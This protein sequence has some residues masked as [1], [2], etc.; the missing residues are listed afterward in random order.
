MS[1]IH[2]VQLSYNELRNISPEAARQAIIA[3]YESTGQNVLKTAEILQTSRPTIYKALQKKRDKSLEDTSRAPHHVHNKTPVD[4]EEKVLKLKERINFGPERLQEE[5]RLQYQIDLP[6]STIRN[7]L[8]R[9]KDRLK[10]KRKRI[11]RVKKAPREFVDWYNSTA[12]EIV[13][14]DLKHI[15]DQKALSEEQI[16]HIYRHGLPLYQFGALDV[17]SR[18]KLVGYAYEKTW[19]N[20]LTWFLWVTSWIRSHGYTGGIVYTVDHGEEFGGDCWYKVADLKKLLKG[21]GVKLIQNRKKHPEE[22]AHLERSHRTDDEEFYMPR[23]QTI[24]STQ[25]FFTEA[26]NYIY[27]YNCVRKHSGIEYKTPFM[28]LQTEVPTIDDTIKYVPPIFLDQLSVDLGPWSGYHV[29]AYYLKAL[30]LY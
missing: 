19:T 3:I 24:T 8:R 1:E 2:G 17:S 23:I 13:Q 11:Q 25:Q 10:G 12:F 16:R 9:N 22:N 26:L 14:I 4:I 20:G 28:K 30:R 29:L 18:F 5:L 27:Y 7:I 21:F 15:V 6:S